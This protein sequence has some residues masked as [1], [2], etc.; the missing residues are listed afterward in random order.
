MSTRMHKNRSTQF[1][2]HRENLSLKT[3]PCWWQP[4]L[5]SKIWKGTFRRNGQFREVNKTAG[6]SRSTLEADSSENKRSGKPL[7]CLLCVVFPPRRLRS[8]WTE[9]WN[10]FF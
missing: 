1:G 5:E 6:V 4:E 3:H 10:F 9:G 8:R 2:I 7:N